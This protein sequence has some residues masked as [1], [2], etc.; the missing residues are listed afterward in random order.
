MESENKKTVTLTNEEAKLVR[1]IEELRQDM[2]TPYRKECIEDA[3]FG[4]RDYHGISD[5]EISA[6]DNFKIPF[7]YTITNHRLSTLWANPSSATFVT[8]DEN[9][10]NNVELYKQVN[11]YDKQIS[12]Y[13]S[14]Y[15]D[16][17]RTAH[18]EGSC[19]FGVDWEEV[20]NSE[21][22]CEGIPC[23]K[24]SRIRMNDFYWDKSARFPREMN[25]GLRRMVMS[26]E[27]YM[28]MFYPL[29]EVEGYKNIDKIPRYGKET[30]ESCFDERWEETGGDTVTLWHFESRAF[31]EDD[32]LVKK[33]VL[34][35]N[36]IPIYE[37]NKLTIP[38]INNVDILPWSKIDCIPSGQMVGKSIPIVI[39]H[40]AEAFNRLLTLTVAQGELAT[41][42]PIFVRGG[43]TKQFSDYPVYPGVTIPISGSGKSIQEDYQIMQLPDITQGAQKL[44]ND[45]VEYIIMT[46]GVDI[47]A[48]FVPASEKAITTENK[49]Q[50][51]EKLL[52]FTILNNE[53]NGFYDMELMRMALIQHKYPET[54]TFLEKEFGKETVREGYIK[55][56]IK[57]Y[58]VEKTT[59]KGK[60]LYKLNFKKGAYTKLEI[61][62]DQLQFNVDMIIEGAT[63]RS[64][65]DSIKRKNFIENL[66]VLMSIPPFAEKLGKNPEKAF[67]YTLKEAG[68]P[69]GE[70]VEIESVSSEDE[71]PAIKEITAIK[72]VDILEK[73]GFKV[74]DEI[75]EPE[76]Y[77]PKEYVDI[78][79]EQQRLGTKDFSKKA[80]DIFNKRYAEHLKNSQHPY[81]MDLQRQ[82]EEEQD[83]QEAQQNGQEMQQGAAN[84]PQPQEQD[85]SLMSQTRS[86][87]ATI[88]QQTQ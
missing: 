1:K 4:I 2:D 25:H 83:Q 47:K 44:M 39:R 75:P 65:D 79:E 41:S 84:I 42:P 36:G 64:E 51:Q 26:R 58:S 87:A 8:V 57:D 28:R 77:N 22:Y 16:L 48:L 61:T 12:R 27:Q 72:L 71:H 6:L 10:E 46:V 34:L 40:P 24:V 81:F 9:K 18:I 20:I 66:Q 59:K 49:R 55:V 37:S 19:F 7:S 82:K 50:I 17:E 11:E 69:E 56:P 74:P 35:A 43:A 21:G 5:Y 86:R 3:E 13:K 31:F 78:F 88:A 63:T 52:R 73:Q 85:Q 67:K 70:F 45:L 54:R 33:K 62:P 30:I 29:K 53:E 23:T 15:Q 38:S 32:K 80:L 76:V 60:H 14:I 68:I